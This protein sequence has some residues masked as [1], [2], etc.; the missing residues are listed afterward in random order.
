MATRNFWITLDIDGRSTTV[1]TGPV[2]KDGG[3]SLRIQQRSAG[4][5]TLVAR[6]E[7]RVRADGTLA[8]NVLTY[9]GEGVSLEQDRHDMSLVTVR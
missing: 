1:E 7:G 9:P 4:G 2:S 3:F 6:I 5:R 8:T